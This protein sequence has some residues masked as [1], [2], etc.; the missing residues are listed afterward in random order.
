M[1]IHITTCHLHSR[2][3]VQDMEL[4]ATENGSAA[5]AASTAA[6]SA[7]AEELAHACSQR[8]FI[9]LSQPLQAVANSGMTDAAVLLHEIT[10]PLCTAVYAG[11][12]GHRSIPLA[13]EAVRLLLHMLDGCPGHVRR[14]ALRVMHALVRAAP[15]AGGAPS[16]Q[17]L[18]APLLSTLLAES[19]G[20]CGAEAS[21]ILSAIA[22]LD[23]RAPT[24]SNV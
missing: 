2:Q 9:Q 22:L 11:R 6:A 16:L 20:A 5:A 1:V 24:P 17:M 13:V 23:C 7:V 4:A 14:H 3:R 19:H 8:G 12:A 15:P 18:G 21:Q 10:A